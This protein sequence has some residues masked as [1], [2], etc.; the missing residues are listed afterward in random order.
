MRRVSG[1]DWQELNAYADGELDGAA[2]LALAR[3]LAHDPDLAKALAEVHAT[4]AALSLLRPSGSGA[5]EPG[6]AQP[7][8]GDPGAA[9]RGASARAGVRRA[10]LAVSLAAVLALGAL[11]LALAPGDGWHGS[12]AALHESFSAQAYV[13]PETDRSPLISTARIGD[14]RAVDLSASRLALVDVRSLSRDGR[15]V[16]A[17]HYRGRNGCRVTLVALEAAAG[18]AAPRPRGGGLSAGWTA[19]GI[20]Y[21]LLAGG[22]DRTRFDSIAAYARAETRRFP[23]RDELRLAMRASTDGARPC[24]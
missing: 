11:H 23:A 3:R 13:L 17:M 21:T 14:L 24:A 5:T 20:H 4:K 7:D 9:R 16:V 1:N 6:A 18:E 22:M 2:R 10:A 15:D 8:A 12:P 19:G